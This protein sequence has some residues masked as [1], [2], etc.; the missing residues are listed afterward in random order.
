VLFRSGADVVNE[1]GSEAV[2]L[3]VIEGVSSLTERFPLYEHRQRKAVQP[4][5]MG[6]D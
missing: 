2:R 1:P 5:A 4:E 6:A 3:K